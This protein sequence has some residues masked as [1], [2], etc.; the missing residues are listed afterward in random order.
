MAA[1]TKFQLSHAYPY[2]A[3]SFALVLVLS[4]I[5]FNEPI[6]ATKVAGIALITAGIVV[7]SAL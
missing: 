7:G 4:A 2:M 3:L 5:F 6:T 1:M